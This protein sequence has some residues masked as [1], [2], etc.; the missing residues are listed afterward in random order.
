M[1]IPPSSGLYLKS[2]RFNGNDVLSKPLKFSGA[3]AG[4]F[5]VI[6]GTG[7]LGQIAGNVTDAQS[8]AVPSTLV[9]AVPLEKG[10]ITDYRSTVADQYGRYTLGGL[11]PGDYQL[12]SWESIESGA[13]YD[14]EFMKQY[15]QQGKIIHVGESSSQNVDVRAIPEQ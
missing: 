1:P 15:E 5:E 10:R 6:L 2:I 12:F 14:P 3:A 13:Y 4:E 7:G 11:T 8:K 9:V